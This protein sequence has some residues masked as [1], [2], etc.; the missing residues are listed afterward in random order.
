M[1]INIRTKNRTANFSYPAS[2]AAVVF[3]GHLSVR[4][5]FRLD[6]ISPAPDSYRGPPLLV[7]SY[8]GG[9]C[10][11]THDRQGTN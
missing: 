5:V 1:E 7:V 6:R 4:A 10:T 9:Y 2:A 3:G 11:E 8:V